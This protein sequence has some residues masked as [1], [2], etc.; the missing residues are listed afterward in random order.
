MQ[1]V[2][3]SR[4]G[5]PQDHTGKRFGMWTVLSV[6][7]K[8]ARTRWLCRCDCGTEKLVQ[9][10]H[11]TSGR[12]T[13]CGCTRMGRLRAARL[14]HGASE[15]AEHKIWCRM[16]CRCHTPSVPD[17]P[18]YGGR[19]IYVCDRWR[20]SFEAFLAD[21]GPRPSPKHSVDRIDNDGPYSPENC[22]WATAKEQCR[23]TRRNRIV[24]YQGRQMSLA[25]AVELSG[26][27]YGTVKWRLQNGRSE[28][29]AFL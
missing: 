29:E 25:E 20:N 27:N 24:T 22:R 23:N 6:G 16:I 2:D 19:G 8:A 9:T 11:L 12:S 18:R 1:A 3:G 4:R 10:G 21:M 17:Y 26:L 7:L 28:E 15:T 13:G 14:R 5:H